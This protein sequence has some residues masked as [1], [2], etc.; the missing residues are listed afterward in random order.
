M[1]KYLFSA[2]MVMAVNASAQVANITFDTQDF[3][4]IGVYDNWTN[5][6]FRNG[7]LAGN[8]KVV[9]N[10]DTSI[11]ATLGKA[12]NPTA[13]VVAVERSIYGSNTFGVRIDLK[14]PFRLTK[15][16]QYI[17]IMT[18]MKDKPVSSRMMVIGL[19]K[20]VEEEWSWQDGTDEQFWALSASNVEAQKGWQDI[21]CSFKGFSYSKTEKPN[22]GIDIYTLVIIP[23]VSS[24]TADMHNWAAYFDEILIDDNPGKRFSTDKYAVSFDKNATVT[25]TDRHL[26]G[27]GLTQEG[28][29]LQ[30]ATGFSRYF[31]NDATNTVIFSA[32]AGKQITPKVDYTGRSM[33]AYVYADWNSNGVFEAET[34]MMVTTGFG[35]TIGNPIDPFPVPSATQPGFYR[36][37]YKVDWNSYDPAGNSNATNLITNNGGGIVDVTLD[38]HDTNVTVNQSQ[39]NGNIYLNDGNNTVLSN[40]AHPYGTPMSVKIAPADG[41]T[42]N[43]FTL[44]YGYDID[45]DTP[46]LDDNGNPNYIQVVIPASAISADNTYEIPAE[47]MRGGK[48]ILI[49][50]MQS[51]NEFTVVII[52]APDGQGSL[53][54][55]GKTYTNGQIIEASQFFSAD[56][57]QVNTI[58]GYAVKS[59]ELDGK[60]LI[61]TYAQIKTGDRLTS[62]SQLSNSKAYYIHSTNGEGYL[63][64]NPAVTTQYVSLRGVTKSGTLGNN[65]YK[66]AIDPFNPDNSWQILSDGTKYYLYNIGYKKY[67]TRIDRDYQYTDEMTPLD[68]IRDGGNGIFA[69]HAG[70]DMSETSKYYACIVMDTA[71]QGVRNWTY[72]DHGSTLWITEN[73]NIEVE[74]IFNTLLN[75]TY[76]YYYNGEKK[77][78]ET[79]KTKKGNFYPE[80]TTI[81]DFVSYTLPSGNVNEDVTTDIELTAD[82]PFQSAPDAQSITK[83]Y[84]IAIK[85]TN[86]WRVG[87]DGKTISLTTTKPSDTNDNSKWAFV[88]N[89]FDGYYLYSA[90]AG[91]AVLTSAID[92]STNTGGNTFPFVQALSSKTSSEVNHWY[93]TQSGN[94][95]KGFY[96]AQDGYPGSRLNLRDGKLAFWTGGADEGSTIT[97]VE[98]SI[99]T[100]ITHIDSNQPE[101][102]QCYD[103][104]GRRQDPTQA[105]GIIIL[106]GKKC[107]K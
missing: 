60:N 26:D 102:E 66:D 1:K 17:H 20:R 6:P 31:Y 104:N 106:K 80:P 51:V 48:V 7:T 100:K 71:P 27:V 65:S 74:D 78:E 79:I 34:E 56:D 85:G 53:T 24:P 19:G 92:V 18:L 47:Y 63:C 22:N 105:K 84:N 30:S 11:D 88:G 49:G 98:V 59:K 77:G 8:A 101:N 68:G 15:S 55:A 76:N 32:Q 46:Q 44:R 33:S 67:V 93:I 42:H 94:A 10:P 91:N 64:Y 62:L 40:Y 99:P 95:A 43:G 86:Y 29:T 9:D 45:Q 16:L 50:D 83:W 12:P 57:V 72:D 38:V 13:K 96:M 61:V 25:R 90:T 82:T 41:F 103:L 4:Q 14:E 52:G 5:S 89:P 87:S 39:L 23:D 73:P 28:G 81:P 21:V 36:M 54:Y 69:I 70:G 97:V 35:N 2:L 37:R 107:Y 58:D 75:V 3:K